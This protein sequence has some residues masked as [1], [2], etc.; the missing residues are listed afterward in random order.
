MLKARNATYW[1]ALLILAIT[2]SN[3]QYSVAES[4]NIA[5]GH[6]GALFI[7]VANGRSSISAYSVNNTTGSLTQVEDSPFAAS[8][9]PTSVMV[10][11]DGNFLYAVGIEPN[12]N[13][14]QGILAYRINGNTG[15]LTPVPESPFVLA[16]NPLSVT[17]NH[18]GSIAYVVSRNNSISAYKVGKTGT[19]TRIEGVPFATEIDPRNRPFGDIRNL[20]N[21]LSIAI[22]PLDTFA[23]SV[24][25]GFGDPHKGSISAYR[26]NTTTGAFT[27]VLGSPFAIEDNPVSIAINPAGNFAYVTTWDTEYHIGSVF[28]YSINQSTG[29]ITKVEGSP[30]VAGMD[31]DLLL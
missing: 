2:L 6:C 18:A 23:Y 4:D 16:D 17:V 20:Q 30:Y 29:A 14:S 22:N 26:I 3:C 28:A 21:P 1:Q 8:G 24:N 11:H 9:R 31:P 25:Y 15:A 7:Y 19:L 13:Q 10:N 12:F 5:Q 27:G